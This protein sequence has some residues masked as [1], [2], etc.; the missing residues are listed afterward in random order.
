MASSSQQSRVA[1]GILAGYDFKSLHPSILPASG[2]MPAMLQP[3]RERLQ[4][5][6]GSLFSPGPFLQC[7]GNFWT[8]QRVTSRSPVDDPPRKDNTS[9]TQIV[10]HWGQEELPELLLSEA[11][12]REQALGDRAGAGQ[13]GGQGRCRAAWGTGPVRGSLGDRARA[14]HSVF[15]TAGRK[16]P[17]ESANAWS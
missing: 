12:W 11:K 8:P 1:C 2:S 6:V 13:P 15:P 7:T 16:V 10:T 17:R 9:Q 3:V 5:Q 4:V 14:G